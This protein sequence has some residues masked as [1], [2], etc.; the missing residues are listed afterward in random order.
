MA[1]SRAIGLLRTALGHDFAATMLRQYGFPVDK[2]G[3]HAEE[4]VT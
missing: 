3:A 2:P 1:Y 4:F